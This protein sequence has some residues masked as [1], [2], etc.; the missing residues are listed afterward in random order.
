MDP[1]SEASLEGAGAVFEQGD[2]LVGDGRLEEAVMLSRLQRL[3]L[4]EGDGFVENGF[5]ARNVDILADRISEPGAIIGDAGA[6]ALAGMRQPPVLDVALDELP[7]RRAQQVRARHRRLR[8]GERH[9]VLEL[10][11]KA[12]G[13]ARLIEGRPRP[14]TA[15][16][17][18]IEQPAI[19]HDV[20]LPDGRLYL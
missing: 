18:L 2:G 5:V 14:E 9:A 8:R 16:E 3:T 15:G 1:E 13:A 17:R 7:R 12:I 6:H 10:I 20:H 4:Q 11:A 19:E